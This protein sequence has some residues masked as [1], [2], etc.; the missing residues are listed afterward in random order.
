MS[1]ISRNLAA[2]EHTW[3][4]L[5][6]APGLLADTAQALQAALAE[7]QVVRLKPKFVIK[8][9]ASALHASL[10]ATMLTNLAEQTVLLVCAV[11]VVV[12][13]RRGRK[14]SPPS[15]KNPQCLPVRPSVRPPL[16]VEDKFV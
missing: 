3:R 5:Q 16:T 12:R 7:W 15:L 9:A 10:P 1:A 13:P 14:R 6:Q 8:K 11:P 2:L 4:N